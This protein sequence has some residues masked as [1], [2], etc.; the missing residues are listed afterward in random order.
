MKIAFFVTNIT[1]SG[2]TERVS[3][4]LCNYFAT[5]ENLSVEIH[6][7]A[8]HD[9]A[10]FFPLHPGVSVVH[11]GL[12]DYATESNRM[13][14]WMSKLRNTWSIQSSLK[15]VTADILVGTGKHINIYMVLFA[16]RRR[17]KLIGC[18]HF[19]HDI[20]MGSLIRMCRRW[21]YPRLDTLVVLNK[22]DFDYYS[23][24][25]GRVERIPNF[26]SFIAEKPA[27]LSG[28]TVLSIARHSFEKGIDILLEVWKLVADRHEDWTLKIIGD[29]PLLGKHMELCEGL[30]LSGVVKFERVTSRIEAEYLAASFS[31][32]SSRSDAFPMVLLE[33]M[34]CGV[35]TIS[36][37]CAGP[38][39]IIS[40]GKDGML[41]SSGDKVKMAAAVE[42]LINDVH[43]RQELGR[44][45]YRNVQRF[46]VVSIGEQWMQLI[47]EIISK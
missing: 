45:A 44:N 17:H 28:K 4:N 29:G 39:D 43:K 18:E 32:I 41:I 40:N 11:H 26:V 1:N 30:G 3:V 24:F 35:P 6:S 23:G 21:L 2:G 19:S 36:F 46:S 25:V 38:T 7:L 9:G 34:A 20:P 37:D 10:P 47:E 8:T 15:N 14:K 42:T 22:P 13:K 5:R 33:A 31:I 16:E 12:K 27:S